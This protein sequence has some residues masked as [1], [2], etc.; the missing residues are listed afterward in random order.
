MAAGDFSSP[1]SPDAEDL[2]ARG[3]EALDRG[4]TAA[5]TSAF[6]E[7][8]AKF[9]LPAWAARIDFL[10]ARKELESGDARRA[11][12]SL[13]ALDLRPIG[14]EEYRD[15]FLATALA[16]AGKPAE[17][18]AA[19]LRC[20]QARSARQAD[21]ALALAA[22]SRSRVEKREALDLL[23]RA[24]VGQ[25]PSQSEALLGARARLAGELGDD[26]ALARA[27]AQLL[28]T[29]PSAAFDRR[30]PKLLLREARRQLA[31]LADPGRLELAER[32]A[33]A[34]ESTGAL[35]VCDEVLPRELSPLEKRRLH[36]VRARVLSRLGRLDASDREARRVEPGPPAEEKGAALVL[37]ENAL[38]RSLGGRGRRR[39]RTVRD[40]PPEEARRLALLFRAASDA[41]S[42]EDTR[43]RALR[44][45]IGLWVAAGERGAALEDA[46]RITALNPAATWGFEALWRPTWER[47]EAKDYA[48]ALPEIEELASLYPEIAVARRL[49][50]WRA[51]CL[52]RLGKPAEAREAAGGLGCA[53]PPDVYARFAAE[54]KSPCSSPAVSDASEK[55]AIFVRADELLRQRLYGDA[56]WEVDRLEASRG[57]TL[58]RAVAF[59]AL[60]DFAR[61]TAE[62]K[63][64]YPEI[65]TAREGDVPEQ[66]RRLYYPIDR[67]GT[68]DSAAREFGLDRSLLLAIVRQESAFNPK[69]KSKA[70]AA[71]L[72]QLMPGTARRLS[73]IVLKRRFRTAF[74]YDPAVNV[75]LGASYLRSLLDLFQNDVLLAVA[76][77]NAGPGRIGGVVRADPGRSEDERLESF[78]AAETRDYVRRVML[79]SASYRE[80]YPEHE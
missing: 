79:F 15:E 55:S 69:A 27:A 56:L 31:R 68:L 57:R 73:R 28:A 47:I 22:A 35:S 29:R 21:A 53:D 63:S 3:A 20:A 11:A 7:V 24:S 59:F 78:P 30:T 54:W 51:R 46:K 67:G 23:E 71:G 37:A 2:F 52:E 61:A 34:G 18:R 44:S 26:D 10:L 50:Y 77:Y 25:E 9:P 16:R 60:G 1:P 4:D 43:G 62:V 39:N 41:A 45:E 33:E 70:G 42:P 75:R 49:V 66:W 17:A 48:G 76:A 40:L 65:G 74:L 36:L 8:R 58:R 19:Y 12:R 5:A 6:S 14:L 13:S 32:L 72:T 38:R 80:L 64:A